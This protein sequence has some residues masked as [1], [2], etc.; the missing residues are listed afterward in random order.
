MLFTE[1][2]RMYKEAPKKSRRITNGREALGA[3][4]CTLELHGAL[5]V[6]SN[7]TP[8]SF[9]KEIFGSAYRNQ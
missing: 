7:V 2:N 4:I 8:R 9:R 5:P 6:F 3:N 1:E